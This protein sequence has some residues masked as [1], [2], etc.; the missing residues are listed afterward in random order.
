MNL[1]NIF[2][3]SENK[4]SLGNQFRNKRFNF[5]FKKIKKIKKPVTILDV[6]GKINYWEN[7]NLAGNND[8][9]I[10]LLNIDLEESSYSNIKTIKG[11]ATEMNELEDNSYDLT[12]SNSVIEHLYDFK[13]QKKMASEIVR[14]GK[15]HL[16]QTPNKYF[17]L[18][19]HYLLPFFQF[20]PNK[21]KYLILTKTK[22]SRLKRWNQKFAKQYIEE[23]RLLSKKE[24]KTLFPKSKIYYEKFLGM[25]K[26]F[27]AH[28]F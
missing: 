25:N 23:I 15:K 17:F 9:Q 6:G 16:I 26:S 13:N 5:F 11:N 20:F 21:L 4:D 1:K 8:Y 2:D 3:L 28:N 18:E 12:H 24:M 22:L 7:R 19:P 27:T 10:T 14:V